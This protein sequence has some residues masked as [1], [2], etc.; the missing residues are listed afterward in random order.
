MPTASSSS[1]GEGCRAGSGHRHQSVP[2]WTTTEDDRP[3]VEAGCRAIWARECARR[4]G[5]NPFGAGRAMYR[6]QRLD[7]PSR[8]CGPPWGPAGTPRGESSSQY[9]SLR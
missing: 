9:R 5:S 3:T 8:L 6:A 7:G 1:R 4:T 2:Q